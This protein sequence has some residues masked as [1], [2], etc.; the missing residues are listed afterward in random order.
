VEAA[1]AVDDSL[2]I[3]PD[4]VAVN[5]HRLIT[6]MVRY[7]DDLATCDEVEASTRRD[8][9]PWERA[10]IDMGTALRMAADR[11]SRGAGK[12]A[13]KRDDEA[14]TLRAGRAQHLADAATAL[15]AGRDLP[16]VATT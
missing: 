12:G 2:I 10:S 8:L 7:C 13:G 16:A 5:L 1:T 15:G 9:R 4:I 14:G 3:S 11:V 6:V